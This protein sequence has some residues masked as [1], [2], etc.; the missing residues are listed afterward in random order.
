MCNGC[1]ATA[2]RERCIDGS[3]HRI[4]EVGKKVWIYDW[5]AE[6]IL[7]DKEL[8]PDQTVFSLSLPSE[9]EAKKILDAFFKKYR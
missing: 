5:T 2:K 9:D 4:Q 1:P 8:I 7:A 3:L 6:E